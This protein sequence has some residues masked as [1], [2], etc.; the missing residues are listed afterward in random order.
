MITIIINKF[1]EFLG[2]K[3]VGS[4]TLILR[5][6]LKKPLSNT[7]IRQVAFDNRTNNSR[8]HK[9]FKKGLKN[10]DKITPI[11]KV[12]PGWF[13]CGVNGLLHNDMISYNKKLKKYEI[14]ETGKLNINTPYTK[15]PVLSHK[16]YTK[17]INRLQDRIQEIW[18]KN[19]NSYLARYLYNFLDAINGELTEKG[20]ENFDTYSNNFFEDYCQTLELLKKINSHYGY[21]A[22]NKAIKY[23]L[24]ELTN[25]EGS[26]NDK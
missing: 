15:K 6:L 19:N 21:K 11:K 24:I 9:K 8:Y 3:R 1:L 5:T 10:Y 4:G 23:G 16:E 12:P 7:E 14:T 18:Y 22:E 26:K 2:I 13:C 20:W 25:I 17:R